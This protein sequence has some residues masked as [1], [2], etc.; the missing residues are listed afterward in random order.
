MSVSRPNPST[1]DW[2][3]YEIHLSLKCAE[4]GCGVEQH[5]W[6]GTRKAADAEA[7]AAGWSMPRNVFAYC[8][9][10]KGVPP[11]FK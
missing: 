2:R 6:A 3:I 7:R 5:F 4:L 11:S 1:T 8:D 10:H 9:K